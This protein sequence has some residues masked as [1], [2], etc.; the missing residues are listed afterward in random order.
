MECFLR[1][2]ASLS[3]FSR[4]RNCRQSLCSSKRSCRM[5]NSSARRCAFAAAEYFP[6]RQLARWQR[7]RP[8]AVRGPVDAPPCTRQ[9]VYRRVRLLHI[10]GARQGVPPRV[11]APQRG[12]FDG[13]PGEFPCL[14]VAARF[15]TE[16]SLCIGSDVDFAKLQLPLCTFWPSLQFFSSFSER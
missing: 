16:S 12:D 7:W 1:F 6:F 15:A 10:A 5:K 2:S 8:S 3:S 13:S 11:F 14:S 4:S 9:R